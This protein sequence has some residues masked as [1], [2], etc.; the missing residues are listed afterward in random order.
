[1]EGTEEDGKAAVVGAL[2]L[3]LDFINIFLYLLRLFGRKRKRS[4]AK[5]A[6]TAFRLVLPRLRSRLQS[7]RGLAPGSVGSAYLL[8]PVSSGSASIAKP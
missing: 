8:L 2:A 1:M 4:E 7:G 5:A 6:L 3:Y